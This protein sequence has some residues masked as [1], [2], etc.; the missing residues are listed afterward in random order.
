V[1]SL[2]WAAIGAVILAA[3]LWGSTGTIQ[4]LLPEGRAP[5]AV[6]ALRLIVGAATLLLMAAVRPDSRAAFA[7]LPWRGVA[8]SGI[9]ICAYNLLF[10]WSVSLTGVGIG[11]A[12]TI[13]SAPVWTSLY[14][15]AIAR[16]RPPPRALVG[17]AISI[18]GVLILATS[19]Q[20]GQAGGVGILLAL[21]AG[22]CYAAYSVSTSRIG[23]T[24]PSVSIAAATFLVAAL[25]AAPV[26]IFVPLG[27]L[28]GPVPWAA[29]AFLGIGA[30]GLSYALYTWGLT[31]ITASS[32]VTLALVEPLTAWILATVVVLEPLTSGAVLGAL[33]VFA[34][35]V[36]VT[37]A[38]AR[39]RAPLSNA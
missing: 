11:T 33:L 26:L 39:A 6:G 21:G 34:G 15:I 22:A 24:A 14:E 20:S 13:G 3:A 30:T 29:M 31:H 28:A 18:M 9:A 8:F 25:C 4:A 12:I 27:W 37:T 17:Q 2:R 1:I 23:H 16:R 5:V 35:L 10:F 7:G 38:S 19:G 36:L 32:A